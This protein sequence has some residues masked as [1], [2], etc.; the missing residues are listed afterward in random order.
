MGTLR[1]ESYYVSFYVLSA[2]SP[3]VTKYNN[4]YNLL[5]CLRCHNFV[6]ICT[7]YVNFDN[8]LIMFV[9]LVPVFS[10]LFGVDT[11]YCGVEFFI[12]L[13]GGF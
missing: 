3:C 6:T 9:N 8:Y 10:L 7:S 4:L 12:A 11:H 13:G 1:I 5:H 2:L